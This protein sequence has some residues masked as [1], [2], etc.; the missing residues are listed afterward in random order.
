[1]TGKVKGE[2]RKEE[3]GVQTLEKEGHHMDTIGTNKKGSKTGR[4]RRKGGTKKTPNHNP[5]NRGA[6]RRS[7]KKQTTNKGGG[8]GGGNEEE[9]KRS[10]AIE[11]L[12]VVKRK[13]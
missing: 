3:T 8:G 7:L 2:E 10:G 5:R 6:K 9:K 1:L 11:V 4:V 12:G 13:R